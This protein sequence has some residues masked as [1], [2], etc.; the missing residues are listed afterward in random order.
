[1]LPGKPALFLCIFAAGVC[2]EALP[3]KASAARL[4]PAAFGVCAAA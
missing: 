4:L 3:G 1:V 2:F